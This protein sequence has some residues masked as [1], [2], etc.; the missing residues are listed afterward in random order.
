M[1]SSRASSPACGVRTVGAAPLERLELPERVGVEHDRQL[2]PLEQEAHEVARPVAAA[3][4]GA[5]RDRV[6]P[7][8]R[9]EHRVGRRAA[10]AGP[11]SPRAAAA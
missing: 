2:E 4:P 11:P 9:L 8:G 1:P 5:D 10:A 3:E 7:L 6:G